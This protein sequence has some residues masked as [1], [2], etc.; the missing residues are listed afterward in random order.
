MYIYRGVHI[1]MYA[2]HVRKYI[3]IIIQAS[4][5][6][7]APG[8]GPKRPKRAQNAPPSEMGMPLSRLFFAVVLLLRLRASPWTPFGHRVVALGPFLALGLSPLPMVSGR[9]S[10]W[11]HVSANLVTSIPC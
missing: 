1:N 6:C 5:N 10:M 4:Q 7:C 2:I 11:P 8:A 3:C 9:V